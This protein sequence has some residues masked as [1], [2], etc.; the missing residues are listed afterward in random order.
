M[1]PIMTKAPFD[2]DGLVW[3]MAISR[4][5]GNPP[6]TRMRFHLSTENSTGFDLSLDQILSCIDR[7]ILAGHVPCWRDGGVWRQSAG[8]QPR[9]DSALTPMQE[10]MFEALVAVS[11]LKASRIDAIVE[12]E[13][14]DGHVAYMA[15]GVFLQCLAAS[16]WLGAVPPLD[17]DWARI[18]IPGWLAESV[19][20]IRFLTL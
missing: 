3:L 10:E 15:V 16:A 12:M 6:G 9:S 7:L 19:H 4:H 2:T 1:F 8:P 18:A 17:P 5:P 14:T 11:T 13:I 20:K